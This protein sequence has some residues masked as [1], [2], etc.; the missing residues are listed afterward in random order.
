MNVGNPSLYC[1]QTR[2][3]G[4]AAWR[5]GFSAF[6]LLLAPPLAFRTSSRRQGQGCARARVLAQRRHCN[7]FKRVVMRLCCRLHRGALP[8]CHETAARG[9]YSAR[10]RCPPARHCLRSCFPPACPKVLVPQATHL[11]PS[12]LHCW[13]CGT[14]WRVCRPCIPTGPAAIRA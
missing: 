14:A 11:P 13:T 7:A 2:T 6:A 3:S 9:C 5:R 8:E 10:W 4:P 12:A 1:M